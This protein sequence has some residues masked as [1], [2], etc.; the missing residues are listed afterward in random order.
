LAVAL[1][2][3]LAAGTARA[4]SFTLLHTF[5][6][7]PDGAFP[8]GG[9]IVGRDGNFYGETQSGGAHD[10]GTVYRITPAGALTIIHSMAGLE[11]NDPFGELALGRDG[12]FYGTT[13]LGGTGVFTGSGVVYRVTP[14]GALTTLHVFTGGDDGQ[15]PETGLLRAPDGNF[16]GTTSAGGATG[17]GTIFRI[18]PSGTLTTL[19]AF[20]G[21]DGSFANAALILGPDG[22]F[23]GT[24]EN[25]GTAN[26]GTV[27]RV[28]PSG[29]FTSLH[30]FTFDAGDGNGPRGSLAVGADGNFYGTTEFGGAF[31]HGTTFRITPA[32]ATTILHSFT[33]FDGESPFAGL[34]LTSDGRFYG[35][36]TNLGPAGSG[37]IYAMTPAGAVTTQ[38]PLSP[39]DG[40]SSVGQLLQTGDGTIYGTN[41]SEGPGFAVGDV[42]KLVPG[43]AFTSPFVQVNTQFFTEDDVSLS[44][45]APITALTLAITAQVTPGLVFSGQFQDVGSQIT[46]RHVITSNTVAYVFVLNPGATIPA[47]TFRF[48]AQAQTSGVT[49]DVHGDTFRLTYTSGGRILNQLASF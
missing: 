7:N 45:S 3:A 30:S 16:Y 29:A 10:F 44:T 26:G 27:Y 28:S 14:G 5:G 35:T 40:T 32:G 49:H 47:G 4:Q 37:T 22:N 34:T 20:T 15:F 25:G 1:P 9:L 21:T 2:V 42:F 11:A 12:N 33:G 36:T 19:H 41:S 43:P 31:L 24:T 48:A 8:N 18:T 13:A 46:E 23:Y 6:G 38:F 39:F 17:N